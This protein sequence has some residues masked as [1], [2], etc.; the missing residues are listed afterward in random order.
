MTN[1]QTQ[2]TTQTQVS[3]PAGSLAGAIGTQVLTKAPAQKPEPKSTWMTPLQEQQAREAA[4]RRSVFLPEEHLIVNTSLRRA[5]DLKFAIDTELSKKA[6]DNY[7]AY[8]RLDESVPDT[9]ARLWK[10]PFRATA[11]VGVSM[12]QTAERTLAGGVGFVGDWMSRN[13]QIEN[14]RIA[15]YEAL[16]DLTAGGEPLTVEAANRQAQQKT[17]IEQRYQAQ[18]QQI[19]ADY[20][21]NRQLGRNALL[22][23]SENHQNFRKQAGIERTENDGF[24]YDLFNAAGSLAAAIGLTVLTGSPAAAAIAFGSTA[25]QQDYEEALKNG[26]SPNRALLAGVAGGVYEGG[27]ELLGM[28]MLFKSLTRAGVLGRIAAAALS[29]G[30]EEAA[31]QTA[32][33]IIMQN[34]GGRAQEMGETLKGIGYS[35][36]LGALTAAPVAVLVNRASNELQEQGVPKE[37]ADQMAVKMAQ[38]VN[39]PENRE[40]VHDILSNATSPLNYREGDVIKGAQDFKQAIDKARN[41]DPETRRA[42]YN[43]ADKMEEKARQQGYSDTEAQLLGTVA[44]SR[45]VTLHNT[46]GL[47]ANEFEETEVEF[48]QAEPEP[49]PQDDA[50]YEQ[51]HQEYLARKQAENDAANAEM[52]RRL[53]ELGDEDLFFQEPVYKDGKADTNTK[54]FKQFFGNSKVVDENGAPLV[55][56]HGTKADFDTFMP[57]KDGA[58]GQGMYFATSQEYAQGVG[59]N[60]MPVYLSIK[61]P[62]VANGPITGNAEEFTNKLKQQGY[63][64]VINPANGFYVAFEP[65]QI[66]SVYNKGTFDANT[67]NIYY[68]EN[69]LQ[70]KNVSHNELLQENLFDMQMNL[71]DNQQPLIESQASVEE[72]KGASEEDI[73]LKEAANGLFS[74]EEM[75]ETLPPFKPTTKPERIEDF[76]E[77][78]HGAR[79]DLWG[80]YTE[81]MSQE[82]PT[83]ASEI[84]LSKY[85]PEP[86]YEAA[87]AKGVNVNQLAIVKAIHDSIPA[88]PQRY[89]VEK[90]VAGLKAARESANRILNDP[91]WAVSYLNISRR[92]TNER[93]SRGVSATDRALFY[94]ALGYPAFTKAKSFRMAY[95]QWNMYNGHRFEKPT[96]VYELKR[97]NSTVYS[98]INSGAVVKRAQELLNENAIAGK[99][100]TK[101]DIYQKR[102]TG[103]III[104]KKIA[105]GKYID[106][107]GG[108]TRVKDAVDFLD[109]NQAH[110]EA[111]LEEKRKVPPTRRET[112]NPRVGKEYRPGNTVVTPERFSQE[113]GFRG[114]QFGNWVE[115]GR[116]AADL[117][118][119]YDALLDMVDI[120]KIP[121]R[122]V[123]L[124]GTLGLAFGARGHKG[125]SAHYERDQVVINLTK[126]H[127]A[128]SLAHEWWHALDNYFGRTRGGMFM[129]T[130]SP[131]RFEAVRP[132]MR[133]AYEQVVK[134][135]RDTIGPRSAEMDK[136][137]TKDYW[138]TPVEMTARAYEAFIIYKGKQQGYSNDYLANIVDIAGWLGPKE[139]YPYPLQSEMP[140]IA[141]AFDNFFNTLKTQESERGYTLYEEDEDISFNF[142]ANVEQNQPQEQSET[143]PTSYRG[144]VTFLQDQNR[145][146]IYA[147]KQADKSTALHEF[148]HVYEHDLYRAEKVSTE[149]EF[150]QMV[151]DL[152]AIHANSSDFV[153]Q[154]LSRTRLL[155]DQSRAIILQNIEQRGGNEYIR[156]L[157]FN[158]EMDAQDTTAQFVRRAFRENFSTLAEK[159]FMN[160]KAP[161]ATYKNLF[162]RFAAWLREIYGALTHVELSPEVQEFFDKLLTRETSKLDSK[163]F[164]GKVAQ[165]KEQVNNIKQ[166]KVAGDFTLDQI[167]AL[168]DMA[169]RRAPRLPDT[170]LLKDLR[171]YGADYKNAGR[172]DAESFKNKRIFNKKGGVGD[173]PYRWLVDHGYMASVGDGTQLTYD[174]VDRLNQQA[175]DMIERAMDGEI[176]YPIGTEKQVAEYENYK[177]LIDTLREVFGS[178]AEARKVGKAI[179]T[180]RERGYRVVNKSDLTAMTRGL[181]SLNRLAEE[182]QTKS[183]TERKKENADEAINARAKKIIDRV[184]D[185][186]EKREVE[187]KQ[188]LISKL[189]EAKT[190]DE[191][192]TALYEAFRFLEDAY[193]QTAAGQ[194]E[195]RKI[196]VPRTNWDGVRTQILQAAT[197]ILGDERERVEKA[198]RTL[199]ELAMVGILNDEQ[200]NRREAATRTLE[201]VNSKLNKKYVS[202]VEHTLSSISH[203]TRNDV[204]GI[205]SRLSKHVLTSTGLSE[206]MLNSLIIEPAMRAQMNNYDKY[207]GGKIGNVLGQKPF[208]RIT[209]NNT[210]RAKFTVDAMNFLA[211]AKADWN[212]TLKEAKERYG[213]EMQA[214]ESETPENAPDL[215]TVLRRRLLELRA[216][217]PENNGNFAEYYEALQ[218]RA[219]ENYELYNTLLSVVRQDRNFKR[220]EGIRKKVQE[221]NMRT[222]EI[223]AL[224]NR[225]LAPGTETYLLNGG[226]DLQT[227]LS[228]LFGKNT[229]DEYDPAT[230]QLRPLTVDAREEF[231][232]ETN[233]IEEANFKAQAT[234]DIKKCAT[235]AYGL[236][237]DFE[238]VDKMAELKKDT[239]EITNYGYV[240]DQANGELLPIIYKN[241][242]AISHNEPLKQTINRAQI[243][244]MWIWNQNHNFVETANGAEDMGLAGRLDRAYGQTQLN[245]MFSKLTDQDIHFARNLQALAAKHYAAESA[246]HKRIYGFAL[247]QVEFYFPSV[248]ERITDPLEYKA[249]QYSNS[250]APGFIKARAASRMPIQ[251]IADPV[252][253]VSQHLRRVGEFIYSAEKYT[254]N[255]RIFKHQDMRRA[256]LA[257]FGNDKI[258]T[259]LL[260]LLTLQG[261]Q[262]QAYRAKDEFHA[263][264]NKLMN[265]WVKAVMG[266]KLITGIK[267]FA[268]SVSFAENMPVATWIKDFCAGLATPM[269]TVAYMKKM[270][271]YIQ[272]RYE[273]GGMNEAIARAMA[274]DEISPIKHKWNSFTNLALLNTRLGDKAS[275]IFGG[276]PYMKHLIRQGKTP[277]EAARLFEKQATRTLQSSLRVHL[278]EGQA[279]A[280][281]LPA[282]VFLVFKNQQLQYWRKMAEAITAWKNGEM[283]TAQAGKVVFLYSVLNPMVY[284]AL[285]M[286]WLADDDD[287]RAED[288]KRLITSPITQT[289]GAYPFGE[290]VADFFVDNTISIWKEGKMTMPQKAGMPMFDDV[291]KDAAHLVKTV[292][293]DDIELTEFLSCFFDAAKYTGLPTQ[294]IANTAMGAY[295][296]ATGEF[297]RGGMRLAGYTKRRAEKVTGSEE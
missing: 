222:L 7:F 104:G 29:E 55:V 265:G 107:K 240:H 209:S 122:A 154:Y 291:W 117:N 58:L 284:T 84:T 148:F 223:D 233:Q 59:R 120:I 51:Q 294:T 293:A 274:E 198:N 262:L 65:T 25:G 158:D 37:K 22:I 140:A 206:M 75:K 255:Q 88:K 36:V 238:V 180:L 12:W 200:A 246:V 105:S 86:N 45:F 108:F 143:A 118:N 279:A 17:E 136:T 241:G 95:S 208:E 70:A 142:G 134:V 52:D 168:I 49:A 185:Q 4:P 78:I 236:K 266:F 244:T 144:K 268:S 121:A 292:N 127:G 8:Y 269:Q 250:K 11:N 92:I 187:G 213:Q 295:D 137:R 89:G 156:Q 164:T 219:R 197:E 290:G 14:A 1:E 146:I 199:A 285:G 224:N 252:D 190:F 170:H 31:Q 101:L 297:A 186:L 167:E 296:V 210:K 133:A 102:A 288:L 247:P 80:K 202:A 46:A 98:S 162:E 61:N 150:L 281:N 138:S 53:A 67:P 211:S 275:L 50:A 217:Q 203:L 100:P 18:M 231:A 152:R 112:N 149:P 62:Y 239:L 103:E 147:A 254:E 90:W 171:R 169:D 166:G 261:P 82:L 114:V 196:D 264:G 215:W 39:T 278:S 40:A 280:D 38:A 83:D 204:H 259:K 23:M 63:D 60:V 96:L 258:Y 173:D 132:E 189:K 34:Y 115:Q 263:V 109:Q 85:F 242:K 128:G 194:E 124:D 135:V 3:A 130:D 32:E 64:G 192:Q 87:L 179:L 182:L 119:A 193:A 257:K 234:R 27:I 131:L 129:I 226:T 271:P 54:A 97:G 106:L 111:L 205:V 221:E 13:R 116:R 251:K 249:Q 174:D 113:F 110:L 287:D 33:E 218:Q 123:S 16:R 30:T 42:M 48:A 201:Q 237:S 151:Q 19:E 175:Y 68:Q 272:T 28:E 47:K 277:Q 5:A 145:A 184:V 2:N 225:K 76:G 125:A 153:R 163:I 195:Q 181:N 183:A 72:N 43:V 227:M 229:M 93:Y 267:Q 41:P 73:E 159:Y 10:V 26:V 141:A 91:Q 66:K 230:G 126:E 79:K 191:K 289:A 6:K 35:F 161:N 245:A 157:A 178:V 232:P 94:V 276:Y 216:V 283:S 176:I 155:N 177:E 172:I 273:Q 81:A 74:E 15:R 77:K 286:G 57:S 228:M 69:N 188:P 165:L 20:E 253:L 9:T 220:M 212:C 248:T 160:G 21:Y 214:F 99:T 282:R 270:S 44:Q 235:D 256:F 207:M 243:I 260:K 71:F 56:Y 139:M 24:I